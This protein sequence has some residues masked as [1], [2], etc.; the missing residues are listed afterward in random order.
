MKYVGL[1]VMYRL[2]SGLC[3]EDYL[4]FKEAVEH[5]NE[6]FTKMKEAIAEMTEAV[7]KSGVK[8]SI[9]LG[10]CR[11]RAESIDAIELHYVEEG[12]SGG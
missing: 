11:V 10:N 12:E 8:G 9:W 5:D 7:F 3:F 1:S 2:K 6:E 4:E